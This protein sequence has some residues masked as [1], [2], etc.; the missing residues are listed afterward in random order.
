[1]NT[2]YN[3]SVLLADKSTKVVSTPVHVLAQRERER[4]RERA[5]PYVSGIQVVSL[6]IN[7]QIDVGNEKKKF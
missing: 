7:L 3:N 1:L 6:K 5:K 4:E 2:L